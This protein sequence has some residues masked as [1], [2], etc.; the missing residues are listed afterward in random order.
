M[1]KKKKRK[2]NPEW[3]GTLL[4]SKLDFFINYFNILSTISVD[5]SIYSDSSS[6][7]KVQLFLIKEVET[8]RH[9][10]V[11]FF[12]GTIY[13][14]KMEEERKS[15]WSSF[16]TSRAFL[17]KEDSQSTKP[18][19]DLR[20]SHHQSKVKPFWSRNGYCPWQDEKNSYNPAL[21]SGWNPKFKSDTC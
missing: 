10:V 5:N 12:L 6:E 18:A 19:S 2:K 15:H 14:L 11:L 13:F 21:I 1:K 3:L 8:D 7:F 4:E 20:L 9:P 16:A 17:G